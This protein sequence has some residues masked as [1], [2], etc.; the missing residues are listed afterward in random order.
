M[1]VAY[2]SEFVGNDSVYRAVDAPGLEQLIKP[3]DSRSLDDVYCRHILAGRL[4]ELIPDTADEP[5]AQSM[6]ITQAVPIGAH[7]SVPIRLSDGQLFGMFCCLSAR[8]DRSL[9]DRDHQAMRAFA[10]LAAFDIERDLVM[11]READQK[12]D[13]INSLLTGNGIRTVYQPI[14]DLQSGR[15]VGFEAL[16]RID[17]EP[18]RG[19]DQWFHEAQGIGEGV[20]LEIAAI[21][22]ALGGRSR[23]P[24]DPLS[25]HQCLTRDGRKRRA[26]SAPEIG[27]PGPSRPRAH[28]AAADR[29]LRSCPRGSVSNEG[30]WS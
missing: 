22:A 24:E 5:F 1:D 27:R 12:R 19:P 6:P 20:A 4:P 28:R 7:V 21:A 14:V 11:K 10:D 2:A 16:S 15:P 26:A 9:N 29:R 23:I 30:A 17:L 3:G 25:H 13:R 8:S 18:V